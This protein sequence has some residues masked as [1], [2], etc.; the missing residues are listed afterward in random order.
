MK[1]AKDLYGPEPEEIKNA[2]DR[3]NIRYVDVTLI[4]PLK[5]N[6]KA[7][8][9]S[10]TSVSLLRFGLIDPIGINRTT[11][12]NFDGN[13]RVE[14]LQQMRE[15]W[16]GKGRPADKVPRGVAVVGDQWYIPTVDGVELS[17]KDEAPAAAALN[18]IPELGGFD[19]S[20]MAEILKS[21]DGAD[22][23]A[24]GYTAQ[25][26]E[27]ILK[28]VAEFDFGGDADSNRKQDGDETG[29]PKPPSEYVTFSVPVTSPQ[30][31]TIRQALKLAKTK[32]NT[33]H[34]GEALAFM[35][36]EWLESN[37]NEDK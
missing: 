9:I 5:Q 34:S 11:G 12:V 1:N 36:G 23:Q 21:M 10:E 29:D 28:R 16:L 15:Y 14:A 32:S 35:A 2:T 18:R 25:D 24:A 20:A 30:E 27:A 31:R 3:L 8:A 22:A 19:D 6:F 37:G 7:H 33:G 13:G 26:V 4:K 17:A